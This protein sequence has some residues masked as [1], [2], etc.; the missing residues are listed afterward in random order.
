MSARPRETCLDLP[1][2]LLILL[3]RFMCAVKRVPLLKTL[4]VI[5]WL[6]FVVKM[7][8]VS[9]L[10]RVDMLTIDMVNFIKDCMSWRDDSFLIFTDYWDI[11]ILSL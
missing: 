3:R 1:R 5:I 9:G 4:V 11:M 10:V 6:T 7:S 2:D 8:L